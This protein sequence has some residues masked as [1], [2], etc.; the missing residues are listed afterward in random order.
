MFKRQIKTWI[1]TTK[2]TYISILHGVY[3]S[4]LMHINS[5]LGIDLFLLLFFKRLQIYEA[6]IFASQSKMR[7]CFLFISIV[8]LLFDMW[9]PE[10]Q[11][12]K[13]CGFYINVPSYLHLF[14][15]S[16]A[17]LHSILFLIHFHSLLLAYRG[18]GALCFWYLPN[19]IHRF[20]CH[21]LMNFT[22][23]SWIHFTLQSNLFITLKMFKRNIDAS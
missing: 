9:K 4:T 6:Y 17:F 14:L 23:L 5:S 7:F 3:T 8:Y 20:G 1:F 18:T 15:S 10:N 22:S 13:I 19:R 12:T 2:L 16:F 21:I 11:P